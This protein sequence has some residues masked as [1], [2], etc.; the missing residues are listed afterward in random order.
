MEEEHPIKYMSFG[1]PLMDCIGDV[2]QEFIERNHIELDTTIHKKLIDITFL[3][4]FLINSNITNVPGGCQFNAMRVFNWMLDK[5]PTDIV[6]F[7]GSVGDDEYYG[8]VYQDLLLTENIIPVFESIKDQT[9]GLCIVVCCNRDRAHITDL[10]ASTSISKE[11]VERNWNKFKNVKLIYTELFILKTRREICFKLAEFG[12]RDETIYGFNLP[13]AFFIENFT[14][15]ISKLC[16]Y[17]DIIFCNA[18][19]AILFSQV[20]DIKTNG[21]TEDLA[22]QL[23]K[24][25]KKINKNKKRVVVVTSGP[26]PAACCEYDFKTQKVTFCDSFP[27]KNVSAENIVDTNGAGDSFAGGFLSQFM[28]GKSLDKCMIAGHWAASVII[29]KRGCQI[30]NDIRYCPEEN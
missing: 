3:N 8:N 5:D 13:A 27:V 7:L 19:E 17:A 20:L 11:F 24:K 26:L 18:A 16:E 22:E 4:E 23:C 15:D 25:I 14:Q 2:S 10:G 30:P 28:K 12:S 6:G 1:S 21:T 9:T 29:Q